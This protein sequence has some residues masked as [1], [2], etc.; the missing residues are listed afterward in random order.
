MEGR[1][2]GM[3]DEKAPMGPAMA[4]PASAEPKATPPSISMLWG[5]ELGAEPVS[6]SPAGKDDVH[7]NQDKR[8]PGTL[9]SQVVSAACG[10]DVGTD[11]R[12]ELGEEALEHRQGRATSHGTPTA[13]MTKK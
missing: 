6:F 8:L 7:P 10:A 2:S 4:P 9:D 13:T 11:H 1:P 3:A 12:D 5:A